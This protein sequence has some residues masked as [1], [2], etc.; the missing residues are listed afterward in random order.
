MSPQFPLLLEL[1][2]ILPIKS[3]LA[4][5]ANSALSLI[6]E[7]ERSGIDIFI[8]EDLAALF[9]RAKPVLLA[10]I[11]DSTVV[12]DGKKF[13]FLLTKDDSSLQDLFA[14]MHKMGRASLADAISSQFGLTHLFL[15][16]EYR[17]PPHN[18]ANI[19]T[20]TNL[21]IYGYL[22][23]VCLRFLNYLQ[24]L[25][26]R[27][28]TVEIIR[29]WWT[30]EA[31]QGRLMQIGHLCPSKIIKEGILPRHWTTCK[32]PPAF[33]YFRDLQINMGINPK[34]PDDYTL[35]DTTRADK[36]D[37]DAIY[38]RSQRMFGFFYWVTLGWQKSHINSVMPPHIK[39]AGGDEAQAFIDKLS[40]TPYKL[41]N[42]ML[43]T[44][45]LKI[46]P[47][48]PLVITPFDR[49]AYFEA[50]F[51]AQ[52][53]LLVDWLYA[54]AGGSLNIELIFSE[55]KSDDAAYIGMRTK[56]RK[57][58]LDRAVRCM[59]EVF[60][61]YFFI[62]ISLNGEDIGGY[63]KWAQDPV[64]EYIYDA[65]SRHLLPKLNEIPMLLE[66]G[67]RVRKPWDEWYAAEEQGDSGIPSQGL[68]K[69]WFTG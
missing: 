20:Q 1:A 2:N 67:N 3:P 57:L 9:G 6:R 27:L 33:T 47:Q 55:W 65:E 50:R 23:A 14:W 39:R 38:L 49:Q 52:P 45:A 11:S 46:M 24:M 58:C 64:L 59:E 8:G 68:T 36:K 60:R 56:A 15:T 5:T 63:N 44:A 62:D 25:E 51:L 54:V 34:N 69:K 19:N 17:L 30:S 42:S 31:T 10:I 18:A 35:H 43:A 12:R 7:F 41:R 66:L 40:R 16:L 32:S 37:R 61:G 26:D 53:M 28:K 22:I 29:R 48:V 4:Q 21:G 13:N